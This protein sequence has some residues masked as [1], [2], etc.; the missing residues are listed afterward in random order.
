M[1]EVP[2]QTA[3]RFF[4]VM[5]GGQSYLNLLYLLA[6]FPLGVF[7]FVFLT[8]GLS[9]GISLSIVWVG[10]PILLLVGAGWWVLASF[11]RLLAVHLLKED[12][13]EMSH[14]ANEGAGIRARFMKHFTS[15]AAWSSLLYL[16]LKFP[17]GIATFAILAALVCLTLGF[18]TLPFT[19]ELLSEVQ[20]GM[21]F[22]P[23][24][25]A[26]RIDSLADALLGALIGLML[27]PV[28]LHVANGLA[29]VHAKL[30]GLMLRA[31]P[32]ETIIAIVEA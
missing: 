9:L 15:P 26:W 7:Y 8:S 20:V 23:G 1:V 21:F 27:W 25:P 30:A 22:G 24:L 6:A 31:D 17:L 2:K 11:E 18:L 14:P 32:L 5:G 13:H 4:R 19:Y 16:L 10:I 3:V 29:W 28:T 12:M